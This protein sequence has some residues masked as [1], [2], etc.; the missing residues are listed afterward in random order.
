MEGGG[1]LVHL[2]T[3]LG[4]A[5]VGAAIALRLRQPLIIGYVL[6]GVAIG[7]FTPGIIGKTEAIAELAEVGI[8]FLMFVIGVQLSLREL[9]RASRLAVLGVFCR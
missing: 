7:P 3:A 2:V 4:A 1:L 9:I 5:L 6:A 8:I